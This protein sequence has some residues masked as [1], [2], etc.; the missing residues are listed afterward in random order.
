M[1]TCPEDCPKFA[2]CCAPVCP[3]DAC[4][5]HTQH[6]EGE[7]V[8]FYFTEF[9]KEGARGR[10]LP[11]PDGEKCFSLLSRLLPQVVSMYPDIRRSLERAE[12]RGARLG[13]RPGARA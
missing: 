3:L 2:A 12:K 11:L 4:C 8:C 13:I 9:V 5:L 7:P 1:L 10:F 6:V